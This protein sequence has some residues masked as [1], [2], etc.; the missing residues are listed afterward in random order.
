V[1]LVC[2][3]MMFV[4]KVPEMWAWSSSA[5]VTV[6]VVCVTMNQT[7]SYTSP[8]VSSRLHFPFVFEVL[9]PC[10]IQNDV[11]KGANNLC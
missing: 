9:L 1:C 5:S 7:I 11:S 8:S 4:R 10:C 3:Y 2:L 6:D